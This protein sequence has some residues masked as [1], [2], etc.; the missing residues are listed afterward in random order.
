MFKVE[1]LTGEED[2]VKL[3]RAIIRT[4]GVISVSLDHFELGDSSI[5]RILAQVFFFSTCVRASPPKTT[6]CC[7]CPS[8][9]F[10]Q[11]SSR[12]THPAVCVVEGILVGEFL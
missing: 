4:K 10:G 3:E 11:H 6:S 5:M 9:R 12:S 1:G 8:S 2:K 7:P